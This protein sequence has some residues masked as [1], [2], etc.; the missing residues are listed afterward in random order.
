MYS[1]EQP[2]WA[3]VSDAKYLTTEDSED[4]KVRAELLGRSLEPYMGWNV[5]IRQR[6]S[7]T[8]STHKS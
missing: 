1:A 3:P 4:R 7:L 2:F 8:V 6:V 5:H